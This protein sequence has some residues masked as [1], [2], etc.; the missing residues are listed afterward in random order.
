VGGKVV[1]GLDEVKAV[2]V[3]VAKELEGRGVATVLLFSSGALEGNM[4]RARLLVQAYV[5]MLS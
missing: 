2:V 3:D 4:A 1:L 5:D